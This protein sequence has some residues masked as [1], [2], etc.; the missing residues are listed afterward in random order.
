MTC[1]C[2]SSRSDC[3]DVSRWKG[4]GAKW[5]TIPDSELIGIRGR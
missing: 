4:L 5:A 3:L 2:M 1:N